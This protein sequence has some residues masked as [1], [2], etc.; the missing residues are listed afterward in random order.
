M[1]PP[2]LDLSSDVF[3]YLLK[4]L[5]NPFF[6]SCLCKKWIQYLK[7]APMACF[8]DSQKWNESNDFAWWNP[9]TKKFRV[10]CW[11][12]GANGSVKAM[13][14]LA[15]C[16][17]RGIGVRIQK[18]KAFQLYV[19]VM[20]TT[21][22]PHHSEALCRVSECYRCGE[23]TV[24][25]MRSTKWMLRGLKTPCAQLCQMKIQY[26]PDHSAHEGKKPP[27]ERLER[28]V[29]RLCTQSDPGMYYYLA[30]C[31]ETLYNTRKNNEL[32]FT[33]FVG[34]ARVK[35][36]DAVRRVALYRL[37]RGIDVQHAIESL[38]RLVLYDGCVES[39]RILVT[40]F[41]KSN[42][43]KEAKK[44]FLISHKDAN[45][46]PKLDL[47]LAN[48]DAPQDLETF[49]FWEIAFERLSD[50]SSFKI[51]PCTASCELCHNTLVRATWFLSRIDL[52]SY[53]KEGPP[54]V[55][56]SDACEA[57]A[58]EITDVWKKLRKKKRFDVDDFRVVFSILVK[59]DVAR[60]YLLLS[61]QVEDKSPLIFKGRS[62]TAL[63]LLNKALELQPNLGRAYLAKAARVTSPKEKIEL[64][65][66]AQQHEPSLSEPY[67]KLIHE[68]KT[69]DATVTLSQLGPCS[70]MDLRVFA[71]L[72]ECGEEYCPESSLYLVQGIDDGKNAWYVVEVYP[73]HLP[74]FLKQ[75]KSP[76]IP[77]EKYGRVL[78][79]KYGSSPTLTLE[80]GMKARSH[81][82]NSL[83]WP[84]SNDVN[85]WLS[86]D[87]ICSSLKG[88]LLEVP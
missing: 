46:R 48:Q 76:I 86:I 18:D 84:V 35:D 30:R 61:W 85:K 44:W 56:S 52:K 74:A 45:G 51:P 11:A 19:D 15:R 16:Y 58:K 29:E 62:W 87:E 39:G 53:A 36:V 57:E 72:V 49:L 37:A 40:H 14:K 80:M 75:L 17:E 31:L 81:Y 28:E 26:D 12:W 8:L 20:E 6:Y 69:E 27:L 1:N 50:V 32:A 79:S 59:H 47:C 83:Q 33:L 5:Y 88:I 63:S 24:Q 22:D 23:G 70:V 77:L 67:M 41:V 64:L 73:L 13:I 55:L 34:G 78:Q 54:L 60:F 4:F 82:K 10:A 65:V 38:Q 42:D 66:K 21:S 25:D 71:G 43:L 3:V 68:M 7:S 2:I 9:A